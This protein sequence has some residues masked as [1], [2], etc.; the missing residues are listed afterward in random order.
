MWIDKSFKNGVFNIDTLEEILEEYIF[1]KYDLLGSYSSKG[2]IIIHVGIYS[3]IFL[4][5]INNRICEITF[6]QYNENN[7]ID[8]NPIGRP[9]KPLSTDLECV[10]KVEIYD[11]YE[12]VIDNVENFICMY[13]DGF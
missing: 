10:W 4:S 8:K 12:D 7:I 3:E 1:K 2:A 11:G 5:I 6:K 13:N 9:S